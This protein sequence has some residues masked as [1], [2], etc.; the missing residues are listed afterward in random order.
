MSELIA[1]H[2]CDLLVNVGGLQTGSRAHCPRCGHFLTRYQQDAMSRVLAYAVAAIIFLS[3]AN[4]Y[5]FLS[6]SSSGLESVMTLRE[7]P[8]SLIRLGMPTLGIM[9]AAFII[10]IPALILMLI[11]LVSAP[12]MFDLRVPWLGLA[13]RSLFTLQSWSM[14]DVFIIAVIVS[15]VKVASLATVILGISFWAY[16]AFSICFTLALVTFDHYQC[17]EMIETLEADQ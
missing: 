16:I 17:W 4:S 1:C 9:V 13:A 12:L 5:A 2:G 15:L 7:A 6:F 14:A 8:A 10:V 3:L 11:V